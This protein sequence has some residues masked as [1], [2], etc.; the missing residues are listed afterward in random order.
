[1]DFILTGIGII[2]MI[3]GIIGCVLPFLKLVASGMMTWYF[4]KE[5]ITG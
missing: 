3:I 5:L 1:M 4:V 2:L